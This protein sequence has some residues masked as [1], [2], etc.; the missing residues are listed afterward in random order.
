MAKALRKAE[1]S[2]AAYGDRD[3]DPLSDSEPPWLR[4]LQQ[5]KMPAQQANMLAYGYNAYDWWGQYDPYANGRDDRYYGNGYQSNGKY[6][7]YG[8]NGFQNNYGS[9]GQYNGSTTK[10]FHPVRR[11]MRARRRT[12]PA[13]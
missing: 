2:G 4:A 3:D 11:G 6:N 5:A 10:I 13:A 7:Q 12:Q 1:N 9:D 8:P